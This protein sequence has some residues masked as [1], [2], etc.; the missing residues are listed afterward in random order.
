ME[1]GDIERRKRNEEGAPLPLRVYPDTAPLLSVVCQPSLFFCRA[2]NNWSSDYD[3]LYPLPFFFFFLSPLWYTMA[4]KREREREHYSC[5]RGKRS[6][7]NRKRE[8][9]F[10]CRRMAEGRPFAYRSPPPSS[11]PPLSTNTPGAP[12]VMR[13][14]HHRP[15]S[16]I[17]SNVDRHC[18][19]T[20]STWTSFCISL[21]SSVRRYPL[22]LFHRPLCLSFTPCVTR[23]CAAMFHCRRVDSMMGWE[24]A[25]RRGEEKGRGKKKREKKKKIVT[26]K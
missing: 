6:E 10:L 20:H 3:T 21:P 23:L 16:F 26:G 5:I 4:V 12:L 18:P 7:W 22:H 11:S 17:F 8:T 1:K 14:P 2:L 15:F 19:L 25:L 13:D 9:F 24:L